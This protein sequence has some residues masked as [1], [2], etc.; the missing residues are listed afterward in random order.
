MS[1]DLEL[2]STIALADE[3]EKISTSPLKSPA[4][5]LKTRRMRHTRKP[6]KLRIR[7]H[8]QLNHSHS[9]SAVE[10]STTS[11]GRTF[12]TFQL[13]PMRQLDAPHLQE[14]NNEVMR[15][16]AWQKTKHPEAKCIYIPQKVRAGNPNLMKEFAVAQ[17]R[18]RRIRPTLPPKTILPP[19]RIA[20]CKCT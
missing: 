7:E 20:K 1:F 17:C 16:A 3:S 4:A 9:A 10:L 11:D 6:T 18:L 5:L 14:I 13:A 15:Y 12:S 2:S 19:V 8:P